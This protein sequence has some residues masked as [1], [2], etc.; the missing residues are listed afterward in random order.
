MSSSLIYKGVL[1]NTITLE[2]ADKERERLLRTNKWVSIIDASY[3]G[4]KEGDYIVVI[5]KGVDDANLR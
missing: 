4:G 1:Y 2:E 5:T 3:H